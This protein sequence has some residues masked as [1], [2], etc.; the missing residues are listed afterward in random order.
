M[1]QKQQA[2]TNFVNVSAAILTL[3]GLGS[4]IVY[5]NFEANGQLTTGLL[6]LLAVGVL[7]FLLFLLSIGFANL[8]LTD[9]QHPLALPRGSVRA[10]IAFLLIIVFTVFSLYLFN[11]VA[12][13]PG[14]TLEGLTTE[15]MILLGD[16]VVSNQLEADGTYTVQLRTAVTKAGED[17][18]KQIITT[19]GT[20]VTSMASFYFATR[21][22][23]QNVAAKDSKAPEIFSI[24]RGTQAPN[25]TAVIITGQ[26]FYFPK[27]L[28]EQQGKILQPRESPKW[29]NAQIDCVFALPE[30]QAGKWTV[31]VENEDGQA[32]Y[33]DNDFTIAVN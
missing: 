5:G 23:Q 12:G 24:E 7:L 17:I 21:A 25:G 13:E 33:Y 28:L 8:N 26:N 11:I 18:A 4:L 9:N 2:N 10:L 27:V 20:L 3:A 19:V 31:I 32:A 6:L 15:E 29:N 1:L 14:A 16:S 22:S 30:E